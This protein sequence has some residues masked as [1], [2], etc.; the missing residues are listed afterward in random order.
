L[1]SHL[2]LSQLLLRQ[3]DRHPIRALTE[4]DLVPFADA[5]AACRQANMLRYR[6]SED[7]LDLCSIDFTDSGDVALEGIT[8]GGH[9]WLDIDFEAVG[10]Q[11][12][13]AA[14]LTG[15][16]LEKLSDHIIHL[17]QFANDIHRRTFYLVRLLTDT[18]ALNV[19]LALKGRSS[20]SHPVILTPTRREL[21]LGVSR[22]LELEGIPVVAAIELLAEKAATPIALRLAEVGLSDQRPADALEVN[23]YAKTSLFHGQPL[24][25]EPRHF[26]VLVALARE[27][28]TDCGFVPADVLL[29]ELADGRDPDEQPQQEQVAVAISRIRAELRAAAGRPPNSRVQMLRNDRQGGYALTIEKKRV[30]VD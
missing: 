4:A 15:P 13:R 3:L 22:R 27:A 17:G 2:Q 14:G 19:A 12:R 8:P 18:N 23:D 21:A 16:P 1:S 28:S 26:R 10:A 7:D 29:Q 6:R 30:F 20:K 25:L 11:A 24:N 5:L 9:R